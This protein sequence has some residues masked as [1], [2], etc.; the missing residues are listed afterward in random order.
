MLASLVL[1]CH[2]SVH[3]YKGEQRLARLQCCQLRAWAHKGPSGLTE[4]HAFRPI[5]LLHFDPS[6]STFTS[7]AFPNA[8]SR[9]Y[10]PMCNQ[11]LDCTP[12]RPNAE[13]QA[14]VLHSNSSSDTCR[15]S[16][17]SSGASKDS[18]T[19]VIHLLATH[20]GTASKPAVAQALI[21]LTSKA[22]M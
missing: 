8:Q 17:P 6:R 1:S 12:Q 11:S 18:K 7:Q 3:K 20:S 9:L 22:F 2:P 13:P 15:A 5:P 4:A 19:F 16:P 21:T 14:S 10:T